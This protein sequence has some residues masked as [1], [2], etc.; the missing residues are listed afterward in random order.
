MVYGVAGEPAVVPTVWALLA[1]QSRSERGENRESLSWL[2]QAYPRLQ[3]PASL[4]LAHL[5]LRVYGRPPA[6][7]EPD[8]HRLYQSNQLLHS[9]QAV[10][11]ATLALSPLQGWLSWVSREGQVDEE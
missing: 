4:A 9:V 5:C 3:G 10:A 6:P 1:L 2:S 11:W 7:L 8:L